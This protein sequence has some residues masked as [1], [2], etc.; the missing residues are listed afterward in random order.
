MKIYL[1]PEKGNFYKANIKT[2][3][4]YCNTV[5]KLGCHLYGVSPDFTQDDESIKTQVM[6][7]ALPFILEHRDN[8]ALKEMINT[9]NYEEIAQELFVDPILNN[10]YIAEPID[11]EGLFQIQ[12]NEI[13]NKWQEITKI[14]DDH[15]NSL[16]GLYNDCTGNRDGAF[17]TNLKNCIED[18]NNVFFIIANSKHKDEI[19][20][21]LLN[22]G[23][24]REK[25]RN[26]EDLIQ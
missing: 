6:Q 2:L 17:L 14:V 1:L 16:V 21:Q 7:K 11:F 13:Y 15:L 22:Y 10:S 18:N 25:I 3:D 20:E 26:Y 5:A 8:P 23:I 4:S 9:N 19:K 24:Q 12:V